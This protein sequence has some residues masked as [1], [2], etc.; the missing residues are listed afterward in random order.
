MFSMANI[1]DWIASELAK[2]DWS[3]ADL[4]RKAGLSRAAISNLV[5]GNRGLG[6]DTA[7]SIA[8]AFNVPDDVL[9]AAGDLPDK[10]ENHLIK[11]IDHLSNQLTPDEQLGVVEYI[12]MRLKLKG[13][14]NEKRP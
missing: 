11:Q 13:K 3:Q 4:S 7:L 12:K 9:R 6:K 10:V 2:R 5:S 1:G 8:K 14:K